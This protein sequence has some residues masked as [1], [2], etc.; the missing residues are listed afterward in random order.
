[1]VVG[2]VWRRLLHRG[3]ESLHPGA[4]DRERSLVAFCEEV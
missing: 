1:M 4:A 2:F 3:T